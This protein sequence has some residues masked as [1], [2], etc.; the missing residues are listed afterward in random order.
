MSDKPISY[1]PLWTQKYDDMIATADEAVWHIKPG[2]R[3]FVGTGCAHPQALTTALVARASSLADVQIIQ[4]LTLGD[5]PYA[6][7]NLSEHFIVNSFFI[8]ENV[9]NIIQEGVGDYTPIFLS[10]IPRLFS[11]GQLP[12]DAA[13]IHVTPPDEHGLC[14]FGVSVDI[15]KSAAANAK[16][17]IAQVNPRMPRTL[18]DSFIHVNDIDFLVP[19][20]MPLVEVN[21]AKPDE[22]TSKIGEFV[23]ALIED[24]STVELGIGRVPH[25]V[26]QS[27]KDKK[28]LGIHTEMF[29]DALIDMIEAGVIDGSLKTSDKGKVVASFCMGS[30]RL[31][32]YIDNNPIFAFYP[33]EYVNDPFVISRQRRMVAVNVALE[34]DL[35]GQ[36]CADSLGT[37]FY[38]GIGGQVDFNRGAARSDGGKAIIALPSTARNGEV[39]RI[40][41]FLTPGAGVVTTRGDVHYVVTEF[42][43]AY[44]HGKNVQERALALISIAHP[45]YRE[46][47]L[48]EAVKAKYVRPEMADVDTFAVGPQEVKTTYLCSDGTLINFRA[49]HP[50]DEPL[51]RDLFYGVSAET[52][53]RRFMSRMKWL[54]REQVQDFV[55]I[56][57]R[58]EVAVVGT[59][60]EAF[61]EDIICIGRYY[62]DPH[63]NRAEVAFIVDDAWQNRG[64]GSFL[65]KHLITIAKRNGIAGFTAEVLRENK[66]MQ[67]VFHKSGCKVKSQLKDDIYYFELDFS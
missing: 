61:G 54:S 52:L 37:K 48:K 12:L 23:A 18:G 14:S 29:T 50:T 30:Q 28:H 58:T 25:A 1:D 27:L 43:V 31:Y 15:V 8:S 11:S 59:L 47:L 62:L 7:K 36:V 35:T 44:L 22:T 46:H 2:N 57:H 42:G 56:D 40:V 45:K 63:T 67:T 10:E 20:D 5:A 60:S 24:G 51:I 13:L 33:T 38:S 17:V 41:P 4:M 9:R 39:S 26:L 3:V 64:I 65:L 66:A 53:Y 6:A 32:D 16:L 34:V 21:W 49:I 55:Y 19:V